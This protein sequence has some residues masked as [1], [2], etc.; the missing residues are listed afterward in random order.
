MYIIY[1]F[2]LLLLFI[3]FYSINIKEGFSKP[4]IISDLFSREKVKN[5]EKFKSKNNLI[6]KTYKSHE[7]EIMQ[8]N[9]ITNDEIRNKKLG[10]IKNK[11]NSQMKSVCN[12]DLNQ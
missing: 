2:L 3:L 7:K 9:K 6:M 11:F 5:S 4:D 1:F 12:I 8:I 10:E